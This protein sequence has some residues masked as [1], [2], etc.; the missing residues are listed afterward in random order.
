MK[1]ALLLVLLGAC[2]ARGSARVET[3]SAD[4]P[5]EQGTDTSQDLDRSL[6]AVPTPPNDPTVVAPAPMDNLG[7]DPFAGTIDRAG[8]I[9]II[10]Q[11]LGRFFGKLRVA[12]AMDGKRFVGFAV[13]GIEPAWGD[14]GLRPG[15]ILLRVNG[16]VIERP[17]QAMAA[18]ESLRVA[19]EVVV[20]LTREGVPATLRFRIE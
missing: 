5:A 16:Q 12:P 4:E 11:G 17:E 18:F 20:D 2:A 8:L 19:S 9:A 10:D 7:R 6:S 14:I 13:T 1:H 15:D 3:R